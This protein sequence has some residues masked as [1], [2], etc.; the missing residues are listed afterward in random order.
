MNV[1][2]VRPTPSQDLARPARAA[3]LPMLDVIDMLGANE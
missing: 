2:T 3:T 1:T